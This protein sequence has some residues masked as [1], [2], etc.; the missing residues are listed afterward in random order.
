MRIHDMIASRMA[1]KKPRAP[2]AGLP[3]FDK[4][5]QRLA[6]AL[7]RY[8][9]AGSKGPTDRSVTALD[10]QYGFVCF[11]GAFIWRHLNVDL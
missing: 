9:S 4:R 6:M 2:D 1:K 8:A 3:R 11:K 5:P 10:S 7:M